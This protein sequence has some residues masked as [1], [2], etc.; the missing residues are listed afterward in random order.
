MQ[1]HFFSQRLRSF[2]GVDEFSAESEAEADV[3]TATAPLPDAY[4]G[5][6]SGARAVRRA[7]NMRVVT[8]ARLDR[9]FCARAGHRMRYT[10]ARYCIY[11]R[12]LTTT[13]GK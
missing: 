5:G 2:A 10:G 11:E 1:V 4:V 8:G 7:V 13:Y 3:V 6:G 9:A 12:C